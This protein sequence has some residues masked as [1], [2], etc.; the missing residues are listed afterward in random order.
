MGIH[1]RESNAIRTWKPL[2]DID[3]ITISQL[4]QVEV[5]DE[6]YAIREFEVGSGLSLSNELVGIS[7]LQC[8]AQPDL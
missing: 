1:T 6:N 7:H 2:F 5:N 4:N 8:S 3:P